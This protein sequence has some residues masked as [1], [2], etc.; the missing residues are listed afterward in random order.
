[1]ADCEGVDMTEGICTIDGCARRLYAKDLCGRHFYRIARYGTPDDSALVRGGP[2]AGKTCAIEGCEKSLYNSKRGWC[3]M[4]YDRW[5]RHGDVN[6]VKVRMGSGDQITVSGA[7]MRVRAR[8]GPAS[9]HLCQFC[10]GT[11]AHW[12][13]DHQDPD[14]R[15]SDHGPY[16]PDPDRYLPLCVPCHKRFDLDWL[17]A[18]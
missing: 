5:L 14:E 9:T 6:F 13:Y 1:M 18:K 7:H 12:A 11:A 4:H 16:S 15:S 8:R 2:R 3:K 17:A 10:G